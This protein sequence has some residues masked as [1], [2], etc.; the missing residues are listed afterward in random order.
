MVNS[1]TILTS[2]GIKKLN[3]LE[4]L[5]YHRMIYFNEMM[6]KVHSL[7]IRKRDI[8]QTYNL[9][10]RELDKEIENE[11]RKHKRKSNC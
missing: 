7:E 9:T 10:V 8:I 2:N 5:Y 11:I 1:Q 4:T 6:K 3:K